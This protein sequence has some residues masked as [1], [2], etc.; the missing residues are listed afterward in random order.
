METEKKDFL[1]IRGKTLYIWYIYLLRFRELNMFLVFMK[2]W[3]NMYG[4]Q[5]ERIFIKV[6]IKVISGSILFLVN[7]TNLFSKTSW[8]NFSN[9]NS[10]VELK[11][12]EAGGTSKVINQW[13]GFITTRGLFCD[14]NTF[15]SKWYTNR[16]HSEVH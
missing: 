9:S 3:W 15:Y 1:S 8:L 6:S 13:R 2:M 7:M 10:E 14:R 12:P 11:T 5:L 4:L 16:K